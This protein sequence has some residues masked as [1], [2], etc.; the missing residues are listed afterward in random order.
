MAMLDTHF[1][2]LGPTNTM[3]G[4][5]TVSLDFIYFLIINKSIWNFIWVTKNYK[6]NEDK[7]IFIILL[8]ILSNFFI[9]SNC[10]YMMF[11]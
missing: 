2:E 8:K 6:V 9:N 5:N 3:Q 4:K 10:L 11:K 1:F 7:I